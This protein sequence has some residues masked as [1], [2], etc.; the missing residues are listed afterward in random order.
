MLLFQPCDFNFRGE[1]SHHWYISYMLTR[2]ISMQKIQPSFLPWNSL[3]RL[4]SRLYYT[5]AAYPWNISRIVAH[6]FIL[7][8]KNVSALRVFSGI[9]VTICVIFFWNKEQRPAPYQSEN[10]SQGLS[11]HRVGNIFCLIWY[12]R[13]ASEGFIV[14]FSKNGSDWW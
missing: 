5:A 11:W 2:M 8:L 7:Y 13:V 3:S 9:Q 10:V 6:Q 14:R 12:L 4:P 1:R